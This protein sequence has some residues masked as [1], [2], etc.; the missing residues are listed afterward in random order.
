MIWNSWVLFSKYG[1]N[2]N[3]EY[4]V[5]VH[6]SI[7]CLQ[8]IAEA[9]SLN[10]GYLD[11]VGLS[12]ASWILL[13]LFASAICLLQVWSLVRFLLLF[14]I[15]IYMFLPSLMF[16]VIYIDIDRWYRI[17]TASTETITVY[18]MFTWYYDVWRSTF[19]D[20]VPHQT[21]HG[22]FSPVSHQIQF[23]QR[24][25]TSWIAPGVVYT[26]SRSPQGV[27]ASP[28]DPRPVEV[29]GASLETAPFTKAFSRCSV[30]TL[31]YHAYHRDPYLGLK[32]TLPK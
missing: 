17:V 4:C 26:L 2:H 28:H 12:T 15:C 18:N 14:W 13:L 24:S 7:H 11:V 19:D 30:A 1:W 8:A 23:D 9:G 32:K 5:W 22:L 3:S 31:A 21:Q 16:T 10:A 25:S 20:N 6:P 27:S 29:P